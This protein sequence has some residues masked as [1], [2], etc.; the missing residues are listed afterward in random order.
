MNGPVQPVSGLEREALSQNQAW[1]WDGETE[2]QSPPALQGPWTGVIPV[3]LMPSHS[4]VTRWEGEGEGR[5]HTSELDQG[6]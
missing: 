2:L 1:S 5:V 4:R 3:S 6:I